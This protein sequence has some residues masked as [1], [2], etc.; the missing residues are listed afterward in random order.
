MK[1]YNKH[2]K[3][4]ITQVLLLKKLSVLI[5]FILMSTTIFAQKLTITGQIIDPSGE[6]MIGVNIIIKGTTIGTVTDF[7]GNFSLT[8]DSKD[9]LYVSYIGYFNEE[10]PVNGRAKIDITLTQDLTSLD[11]VIVVGYGVQ[12]KS[13]ITGSVASIDVEDLEKMKAPTI[14]QAIQGRAA[15]VVVTASSGSPGSSMNIRIRGTGTINNSDPLYVIDGMPIDNM[16]FINPSDIASMEIL[17]D[18]SSCAIYGARGANGVILITTKSGTEGKGKIVFDANYSFSQLYNKI[19]LANGSEYAMLRAEALRNA[20]TQVPPELNNPAQFGEGTDWQNEITRLAFSHNHNISFSNGTDK[21]TYFLSV[22]NTNQEGI[23]HKTSFKRTSLR[24]NT[25]YKAKKWLKI[26]ENITIENRLRHEI[27]EGNDWAS[28]LI[29]AIN[30]EPTTPSK[31]PDGSWSGSVYTT[32]IANP[33]AQIDRTNNEDKNFN[34]IGNAFAEFSFLNNFKFRSDFGLTHGYN[35]YWNFNPIYRIKVGEEESVN[36]VYESYSI[37]GSKNWTNYFTYNNTFGTHD[38]SVMAGN[39]IYEEHYTWM[40]ATGTDLIS[41]NPYL[42]TMDN[43]RNQQATPDGS[44]DTK[45]NFSYLG[46]INYS[47]KNKYLATINY[48][49]DGSTN[50]GP[51]KR[52]GQF[53]SFSLGWKIS[54]EPFFSSVI[55]MNRLKLRA[56]WGKIGND[57][58]ETFGYMSLSQAGRG[59]VVNGKNVGGT[60]FPQLPNP[61]IRWES[62]ITTNIA[63]DAAFFENQLT[64]VVDLYNKETSDM[65]ILT[66]VPGHVGTEEN[67]WSNRGEM[68]NKGIEVELG[69]KKIFGGFKLDIIGNASYNSNEILD[70]GLTE[71]IDAADFQNLGYVTR[72]QVGHPVASFYGYR[73]DGLFQNQAEI[74]AHVD[75]EGNLLQRDAKPGDIKYADADGDGVLD[76]EFLG[77]P[78]PDFTYGLNIRG[79]YKGFDLTLFLQ[80]VSGNEIFNTTLFYTNNPTTTYNLSKSMIDRWMAEGTTNDPMTPRMD[81]TSGEHKKIS[82]RYIEDGSYL[83]IKVLQLGYTLPSSITSNLNIEKLRIYAGVNNLFT[84]T[85]YTGL[86]PEVGIGVNDPSDP[87]D[88]GIDRVK[89]PQPRVFMAGLSL[90]F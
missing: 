19:D 2:S 31:Q 58:I 85:K 61:N 73:V 64:L 4:K 3:S 79:E 26:G 28:V 51:G 76:R 65:L 84:F 52:Y 45:R 68:S 22:N 54:E 6:T 15:G 72:T 44:N 32:E 42:A 75:G 18:A 39:E 5:L 90:T 86:D 49:M 62:S 50:F 9:T 46:R 25:S 57:K 77:S 21:L 33:A 53:P 70:L 11:E 69:Y 37:G 48:R 40:G 80:G 66:E 63:I 10:I 30:Y 7:E 60:S 12:K 1:T 82:D 36:S 41:N 13:D 78:I 59:Y 16:D 20:G 87:L 8:A 23:V 88:I 43:L 71:Y 34:V 29:Q 74:D 38:I 47:F 83:R 55:F 27:D 17:K 24:L 67:P 81:I 35:R 56:G 89:Y 14:D